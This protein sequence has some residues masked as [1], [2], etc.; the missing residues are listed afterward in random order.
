MSTTT[1]KKRVTPFNEKHTLDYGLKVSGRSLSGLVVES[2][3]CRFCFTFGKEGLQDE[4][5]SDEKRKEHEIRRVTVLLDVGKCQH[6]EDV[7][8]YEFGDKV[9][10]IDASTIARMRKNE[11]L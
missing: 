10:H 8:L 11:A 4:D 1:K 2:V 3:M 9:F 6:I 7:S 5:V